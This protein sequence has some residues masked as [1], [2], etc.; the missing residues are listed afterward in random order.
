MA[1]QPTNVAF[2][3]PKGI[4][5]YP[6]LSQPDTKFSEEGDYKVNLILSKQEAIPILKQINEVYAENISKET[7]KANGKEIKKAAPPWQEEL[8]GDGKPT[9]NVILRFKSKAAYKPA[10]F[11]AKGIPMINSNIWGGSEIKVAGSI[12]PYYTSL[13]GAGV[14]LRLRAVQ[15]IKYV[16]GTQG[17][18][19]FGF[20][21][22]VGYV[23]ENKSD[24]S[25]EEAMEET[26]SAPV[27]EASASEEP[28][29]RA[30]TKPTPQP[31]DDLSDIINQWS[32]D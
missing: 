4:A 15:V 25:F 26:F 24:A 5:Q 7:K 28:E 18:S 20:E 21:E 13:I 30:D 17:P 3:T 8:D 27:E 12:A 1:Q 22:E 19:R 29:L 14:A 2:T 23:H 32:K 10:I 6:W 31:A 11:D 16:D 9:G